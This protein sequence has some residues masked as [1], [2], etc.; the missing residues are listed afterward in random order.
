MPERMVARACLLSARLNNHRDDR[1]SFPSSVH[2]STM[3]LDVVSGPVG[4]AIPLRGFAHH[5]F[6]LLYSPNGG[7]YAI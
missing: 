1:D 4:L 7:V 5:V 6:S 2:P 3:I